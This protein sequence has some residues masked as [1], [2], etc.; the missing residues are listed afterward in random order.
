MLKIVAAEFLF[1]VCRCLVAFSAHPWEGLVVRDSLYRF[2]FFS[3]PGSS[4]SAGDHWDAVDS[5]QLRETCTQDESSRV[6]AFTK[7]SPGIS[8]ICVNIWLP[9][10]EQKPRL[11]W[12]PS[13]PKAPYCLNVPVIFTASS[14]KSTMVALPDPVTF[15]QSRQ[16]QC[17]A[18][19]DCCW[20]Y[21]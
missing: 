16:W 13:E 11:T 17:S 18:A 15:W 6:P 4:L 19:V 21:S 14:G 10:R 9:Q 5:Q 8:S 7:M 20:S 2:G 3:A 12:D 1:D